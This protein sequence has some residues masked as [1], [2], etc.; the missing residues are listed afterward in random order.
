MYNFARFVYCLN[1]DS[2]YLLHPYKPIIKRTYEDHR[3]NFILLNPIYTNKEQDF[4]CNLDN[5]A[6]KTLI[7]GSLDMYENVCNIILSH[8]APDKYGMKDKS[9]DVTDRNI[10][11][12]SDTLNLRVWS[13]GY[14]HEDDYIVDKMLGTHKVLHSR[15]S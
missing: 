5:S 15:S 13:Y 7:E 14:A 10:K 3:L 6:I 9:S 2:S 11:E 4:A 8:F 1:G 12:T